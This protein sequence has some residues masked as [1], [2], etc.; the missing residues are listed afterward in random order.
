M[1]SHRSTAP[2]ALV[3]QGGPTCSHHGV[4]NKDLCCGREGGREPGVRREKNAGEGGV[5]GEEKRDARR[6][7]GAR[8]LTGTEGFGNSFEGFRHKA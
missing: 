2:A 3:K 4:G 5:G 1:D 7:Q 6:K 8:D